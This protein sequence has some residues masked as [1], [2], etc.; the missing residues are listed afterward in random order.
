MRVDIAA[1]T[2]GAQVPSAR[3]RW[4]Q[5]RA[6]LEAEGL[7][8]CELVSRWNAYAP[9]PKAVRPLWLGAAGLDSLQRVL[10]ARRAR[11]RFLQRNLIATLETF[12]PLLSH[13][14]IF[15]VDDAIFLGP[16]GGS[17]DRIARRASLTICGNAF[18]AEHF[19]KLG[20]VTIL[21]TA[22]DAERFHPAQALAPGHPVL[23]WSGSSGGLHYLKGIEPALGEVLRLHPHARL[24]IVA[25]RM[26]R[27]PSLPAAQVEFVPWS[28]DTEVAVLQSSTIGL[29]PLEDDLWARGKCSFKMLT[30]MAVGLPVVVSPV[31]MNQEL[32]AQADCG[33]GARDK[34]DWIEMLSAL[35]ADPGRAAAMGRAGRALVMER[36]DRQVVGTCLAR[37]L[38]EAV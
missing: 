3:F 10:R 28:P 29:M 25:D 11:L 13:P 27:L 8:C 5:H 19:S 22:V 9:A 32:L 6:T 23:V 15:D 18:L 1:L 30:C 36:Y 34:D 33:L 12:E 21:P 17:A 7:R 14:F 20:P 16:R 37:L 26:P 2:Q 35:I 4:Q 31:G 38:K 24:R